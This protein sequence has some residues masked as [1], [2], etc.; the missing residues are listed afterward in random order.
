VFGHHEQ[1]HETLLVTG[2]PKETE[3][4]LD[5]RHERKCRQSSKVIRKFIPF[6]I[7]KHRW[8]N[9]KTLPI[10]MHARVAASR[11][12]GWWEEEHDRQGHEGAAPV[13]C[14]SK[15]EINPSY[16]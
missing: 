3:D 10:F 13:K 1:S 11:N 9:A 4:G 5:G 14:I 2:P 12:G 8:K 15:K 6:P 7:K 16:L